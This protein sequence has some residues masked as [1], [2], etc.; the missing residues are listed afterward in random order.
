MKREDTVYWKIKTSLGRTWVRMRQAR[1]AAAVK[2]AFF[3]WAA[4]AG[5]GKTAV[6]CSPIFLGKSAADGYFQR[7]SMIDRAFF[8]T[9]RRLYLRYDYRTIV[10]EF[11]AWDDDH[12]ELLIGCRAHARMLMRAIPAGGCCYVH[13]AYNAVYPGMRKLL[14]RLRRRKRM[15][16]IWD[17]H[18]AVP[19]E[20]AWMGNGTDLHCLS[21]AF[22]A[23]QADG[24]VCV[25]AAMR[26]HLME[27]YDGIG[28]QFLVLPVFAEDYL[29]PAV[30]AVRHE[31]DAP[32]RSTIVYAGGLQVW[33]NVAR[34]QDLMAETGRQYRFRVYVPEPRRFMDAWGD[35]PLPDD[36]IV[37]TREPAA[38]AEAYAVCDYGLLLRDDCVVNRVAC[39]TK[40]VEYI[41][42]GIVP[43]L[44]TAHVGDFVALGMRFVT[45]EQTRHGG[46]P[47]DTER[48]RMAGENLAVLGA[49]S[50][51][52]RQGRAV[53]LQW[54]KGTE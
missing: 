4:T 25:N 42:Y 47:T 39:P 36:M 51:Q 15:R 40:L 31:A 50:Q 29:T 9:F 11:T 23:R 37:E 12:A 26:A 38:L 16:L 8:S 52:Y 33:Q 27:K 6:I 35:R 5:H 28:G 46:L 45:E 22:L 48:E 44:R 49:L 19:E 18:G 34:M 2:R 53:L 32:R 20:N 21:E 7:V 17:V 54:V 14:L 43:I 1:A 3:A 13:S 24:I 30:R 10:P 41:R